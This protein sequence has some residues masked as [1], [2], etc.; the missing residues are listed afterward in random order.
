MKK[1]ALTLLGVAAATS[2]YGQG[3]FTF[4]DLNSTAAITIGASNGVSGQGAAG[5]FVGTGYTASLYYGPA[6]STSYSQLT[7]FPGANTVFFGN[8]TADPDQTGGAG[9]FDGGTVT[10]PTTGTVDIGVAVWWSG[11]GASGAATSY[12]QAVADGYNTGTS[13]LLPIAL[14]TGTQF[15]VAL[16][17]LASFT[18]VGV[19]P[20]PTTLALCGLGAASLLLF[21]RKK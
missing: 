9:L 13:A 19:V 7:L 20:E 17:N 16:D 18:V 10:L 5:N 3:Q 2:M 8:S 4:N 15:P 11:A 1:L 21:R 6:G 12:A 14:A